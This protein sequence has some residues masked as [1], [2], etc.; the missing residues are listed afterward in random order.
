MILLD[1]V[2]R[3]FHQLQLKFVS[4]NILNIEI[5]HI[6]RE[7]FIYRKLNYKE[8]GGGT[9]ALARNKERSLFPFVAL[10]RRD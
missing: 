1:I 2:K 8:C 3:T 5:L 6:E 4:R 7:P 9:E 10:S